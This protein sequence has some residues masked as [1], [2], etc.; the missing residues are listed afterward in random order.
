MRVKM[1]LMA[2]AVLVTAAPALAQDPG[3][4]ETGLFYRAWMW[5]H[6]TQLNDWSG[7]GGRVGYFFLRNIELEGTVSFTRT[8]LT[9][10]RHADVIPL[11]ARLVW[12]YPASREIGL[13]LGAGYTHVNYG[14]DVSEKDDGVG[15]LAGIL[16]K[17]SD[18]LAVRLEAT[19]DRLG[20]PFNP[21]HKGAVGNFGIQAGVSWYFG[22]APRDSDHDGVPD[23]LDKCPGTPPGTR[24]DAQGCRII[25]DSDHD[26][27][28]DNLDKCPNTPAGVKVDASGCPIDSDRDGVPDYLDK[29]PGTP[30]GVKVDAV[31]CPLDSD[32]DGV[33]DYLDKCP[34]TPA[35]TK[36]D[37]SGCPIRAVFE[38]GKRTLI[39]EGVNFETNKAQLTP[40]SRAVLDKVAESLLAY[41]ELR[42]EVQGHTDSRG[43]KA[44]N[45][46]LSQARA[47]TVREYLISKGVAASRLHAKGYGPSTP[48][49][50]HKTEAG[51]AKNRRV[52]LVK[53]D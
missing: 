15:A 20:R 40:D 19:V 25:E 7:A 22:G 48:I 12:N 34:D 29:C 38:T 17:S 44:L 47:E 5:G 14:G 41:P 16:L 10:S 37:A 43:S 11:T 4:V 50:D 21:I 35:G 23:Y 26:G 36:V 32:H 9:P 2:L 53:I 52:E 27:V 45:T 31:G 18:N 39:L 3:T 46:K 33:P 1:L 30:A 28:P 24:V 49:A 13:L 6:E 8:G 51:R 42:V